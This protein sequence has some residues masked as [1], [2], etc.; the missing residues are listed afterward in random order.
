M[1]AGAENIKSTVLSSPEAML[2]AVDPLLDLMEIDAD[3]IDEPMLFMHQIQM[4][5]PR[6][7]SSRG[8]KRELTRQQVTSGHSFTDEALIQPIY[9][10]ADAL[11]IRGIDEYPYDQAARDAGVIAVTGGR[12]NAM[13]D[14]VDHANAGRTVWTPAAKLYVV[15]SDASLDPTDIEQIRTEVPT[16]DP[17]I[18]TDAAFA[19]Q[20]QKKLPYTHLFVPRAHKADNRDVLR[21]VALSVGEEVTR[22][23]V[24][25][26]A[27]YVPFTT[28][29]AG[30]VAEELSQPG[31]FA[32][33]GAPSNPEA[34]AKRQINTYR[35]E[36]MRTIIG[37]ARWNLE[38]RRRA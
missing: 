29:D 10:A 35:S 21:E 19:I 13:K 3:P 38:K 18:E 6:H 7:T 25:T 11:G 20:L 4:N 23:L 30:A 24:E 14:R 15:G 12:Y 32:V 33:Y 2:A 17:K 28:A 5:D 37:A 27:I 36:V 34:V 26:T 8:E 22:I 16:L 31:L 9:D 1:S